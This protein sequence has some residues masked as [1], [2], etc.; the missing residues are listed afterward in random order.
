MFAVMGWESHPW[1]T[2][3]GRSMSG[4]NPRKAYAKPVLQRREMLAEVTA[5]KKVSPG[6]KKKIK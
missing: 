5:V 4:N 3:K 6:D 1:R 2:E